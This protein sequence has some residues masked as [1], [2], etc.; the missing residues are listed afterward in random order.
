MKKRKTG[1]VSGLY[2]VSFYK[3]GNKGTQRWLQ[4][5]PTFLYDVGNYFSLFRLIVMSCNGPSTRIVFS[6]SPADVFPSNLI[7]KGVF[8]F[9]AV[10]VVNSWPCSVVLEKVLPSSI[11]PSSRTESSVRHGMTLTS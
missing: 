3:G 10:T 9:C 8:I 2:S 4:S 7:Q 1:C 11:A 5:V 6:D